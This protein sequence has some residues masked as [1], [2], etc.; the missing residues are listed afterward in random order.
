PSNTPAPSPG[1]SLGSSPS[2]SASAPPSPSARP[3]ATP[4]PALQAPTTTYPNA[5]LADFPLVYYRLDET[6]CCNAADASGNAN[7]GTYA[8]ASITYG[9]PGLLSGSAD[10]A[11]ATAGVAAVSRD[12]AFLPSGGARTVEIWAKTSS[13]ASQ[14]LFS[15][16]QTQANTR[17]FQLSIRSE[18]RRVGIEW[19]DDRGFDAPY[20][21][22]DGQP[23]HYA[24][25]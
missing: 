5:V 4:K 13:N 1:P 16:G 18:E 10:T 20:P 15:Y 24:L 14:A 3:S 17:Y 9:A 7:T 21:L 11:I 12:A 25:T 8:A 6:G 19:S 23:D 2:P 22:N